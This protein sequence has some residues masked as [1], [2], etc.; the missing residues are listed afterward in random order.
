ME[1][2]KYEQSGI[3]GRLLEFE[4]DVG[5]GVS[6]SGGEHVCARSES[7]LKKGV[8]FSVVVAQRCIWG[9]RAPD[10]KSRRKDGVQPRSH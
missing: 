10:R 4:L 8:K 7:I 2:A 5:K 9:A 3:L 6:S 1:G